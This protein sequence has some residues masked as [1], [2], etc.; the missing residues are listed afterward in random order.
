MVQLDYRFG[1]KLCNSE[2][3]YVFKNI[4][5]ITKLRLQKFILNCKI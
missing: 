3:I 4:F 1:N 2:Y 5:T